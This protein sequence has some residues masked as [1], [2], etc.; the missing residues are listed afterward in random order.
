M[1]PA[2]DPIIAVRPTYRCA[3]PAAV[4]ESVRKQPGLPTSQPT[5]CLLRRVPV[6]LRREA[7]AVSLRHHLGGRPSSRERAGGL[8]RPRTYGGYR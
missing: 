8:G 4:Q 1:R 6:L 5:L 7:V 2:A 3:D